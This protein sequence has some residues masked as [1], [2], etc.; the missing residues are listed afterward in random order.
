MKITLITIITAERVAIVGK[1]FF[2]HLK[3]HQH[4]FPSPSKGLENFLLDTKK[5]TCPLS[6]MPQT[7]QC[8]KSFCKRQPCSLLLFFIFEIVDF[9]SMQ[10]F[11]Q[12][13]IY[14][15]RSQR[16]ESRE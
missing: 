11:T 7:V 5:N 15:V 4:F 12:H 9:S 3:S 8:L 16:G 10:L 6:N 1:P 14:S 13:K 2:F